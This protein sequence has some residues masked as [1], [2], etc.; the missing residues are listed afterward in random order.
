MFR[1]SS[2]TTLLWVMLSGTIFIHAADLIG[3]QHGQ[4]QETEAKQDIISNA[5]SVDGFVSPVDCWLLNTGMID[6][7]MTNTGQLGSNYGCC[8][9]DGA[10][11]PSFVS[12]PGSGLEYLFSGAVWIG[13]I[14]GTDTL[15]TSGQD[16]WLNWQELYPPVEGLLFDYSGYQAV[17][18]LAADT[19]NISDGTDCDCPRIHRP[20]NIRLANRAFYRQSSPENN[21]II[22]D[23][24]I[25]NLGTE[26]ITE[27]FIGLYIDGDVYHTSKSATGFMDDLAGS[28]VD[29]DIAYVIDN[30]GDPGPPDYQYTDLNPTKIMATKFLQSSFEPLVSSFNWWVSNSNAIYDFGPRR[31][32]DYGNPQCS[33]EP[34]QNRGTPILDRHKY[35]YLSNGEW[36]YDMIY[37]A[38]TNDGWEPPPAPQTALDFA[39][40]YDTRYLMALGP[41]NLQPD[42]SIRV[43][44]STFTGDSV[45]TDPMNFENMWDDKDAFLANL[46]FTGVIENAALAEM[47]ADSLLNPTNPVIGLHAQHADLD[48]VVIEWD[49]WVFDGIAGYNIYLQQVPEAAMP[50]P[51]IVPPWAVPDDLIL[52]AGTDRTWR[53]TIEDLEPYR[54]Y[55]VSTSHRVSGGSSQLCEPILFSTGEQIPAPVPDG[56]YVFIQPGE[57]VSFGWEGPEGIDIDHYNIYDFAGWSE[58]IKNY[59]P[60]YDTGAA[61]DSIAPQDSFF[62]DD[63]WYFYYAMEIAFQADGEETS[64]TISSVDDSTVY[65]ITAV[66]T[67]GYESGFSSEIL[68]LHRAPRNREIVVVTSG[69]YTQTFTEHDTIVAFY[70]SVLQGYDFEILKMKDSL[71]FL[72]WKPCEWLWEDLQPF[73]LVI[74]EDG[75]RDGIIEFGPHGGSLS[76]ALE[77]YL[78]NGGTMAYFGS[79]A[80]L[81]FSPR[82]D[83]PPAY[84]PMYNWFGKDYFGIDSVLQ[85]GYLFYIVQLMALPAAEDTLVGMIMA[86]SV[87]DTIPDVAY[88]GS[89]N[90]FI[91]DFERVWSTITAPMA[92]TFIPDTRG[93][94]THLL[95]SLYPQTSL[96]D[97]HAVGVLTETDQSKTYAF[98]FQPWYMNHADFRDLVDFM[99]GKNPLDSE[100]DTPSIPKAFSLSQNRP[101]PFNPNTQISFY[102]PRRSTVRLEVFDILGRKLRTLVDDQREEGEHVVEFDG[103]D[104]DG[105]ELASGIYFYRLK[106][107]DNIEAKKMILLK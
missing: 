8:L 103:R 73:E 80:Q 102:L 11:C 101:N 86:E 48:S 105:I 38:D 106:T 70:D 66:D 98:G 78:L 49:P 42:S 4:P 28:L 24:V 71:S 33:M 37:T 69:R 94:T 17:W 31:V 61:R 44:F 79:F 65:M 5:L 97:G 100:S 74:W 63:V 1:Y 13:G 62:V 51:G 10:D 64:F 81:S 55:F 95:R 83:D 90:L 50:Y 7:T 72:P 26:T 16:G 30:D 36:D 84:K 46:N 39:N 91:P 53:H 40:G 96:V 9:Y 41:F 18:T 87:H 60:F 57:P 58:Y 54:F 82:H 3:H 67:D 52:L 93:E 59:S 88:D 25:T 56:K 19:F 92:S 6:A 76:I 43:L 35:C 47:L 15:V 77:K 45:H 75:M 107:G 20:M 27:G 89:L 32:D 99:M 21:L 85:T 22:Y 23:M 34:A 14:V 104:S 68:V 29:Q 2:V 12:P